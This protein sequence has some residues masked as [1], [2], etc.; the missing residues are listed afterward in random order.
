[1][2]ITLYSLNP[3]C[4]RCVK[5]D[6]LVEQ[7]CHQEGIALNKKSFFASMCFLIWGKLKPPVVLLDGKVIV[8]GQILTKNELLNAIKKNQNK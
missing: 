7:V 4:H 6:L 8:V 1:M 5:M 2:N 3:I